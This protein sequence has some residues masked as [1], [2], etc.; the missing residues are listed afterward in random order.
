VSRGVFRARGG[1]VLAAGLLT[2]PADASPPFAR[3]LAEFAERPHAYASANCFFLVAQQEKRWD[4]AARLLDLLR[5]K[6]PD[7]DWLTL[8]RGN[9]EYSRDPDRALALY[10]QAADGFARTRLAEGEVTAR[11]N[12]RLILYRR[13]R[14]GEA[15][16]EVERAL[17][18]AQASGDPLTLARAWS[19]EA[20][21]LTDT[22]GDLS[23]ALA[24]LRRAE[25]AA[26]PAGSYTLRRG[27]V[28]ALGNACFQLGRFDEALSYYRRVIA[29][30]AETGD[31]LSRASAQYNVV[32][33]ML[34]QSEELPRPGA[35]TELVALAEDALRT[36]A[37]AD[38]REIQV[39][40]HRTLGELSGGR[41]GRSDASRAHYERCVALARR[42][43]Q[44]RELAHCLW[45]LARA[46]A[47]HGRGREARR[48]MD[49]ALALAG[50]TGHLW[51][52]A[53]ASRQRMRVAWATLPR[54]EAVAESLR[55]LSAIEAVRDVQPE[56]TGSAGVFSAWVSDYQ[57]LSGRLLATAPEGR[58][59]ALEQAFAVVER[60][61]ARVLL[62]ALRASRAEAPESQARAA[63]RKEVLARMLEA[64]RGLLDPGASPESRRAI[65]LR[66]EELEA[67][68]RALRPRAGRAV[69][70]P[71]FA[72]LEDVERALE[73]DEALLSY[74]V[75][76]DE[77]LLGEPAG[78][79]WVTV[80]T[81]AGTTAHRVAGRVRL[82]GS[83]PLFLGLFGARDGRE[84]RPAVALYRDVVERAVSGLPAGVGRL[85]VVPDDVLH[86]LPF[87]ALR[88]A[89]DA[90]PLGSRFAVTLAPSATLWLRW[91]R[92]PRPAALEPALVLADPALPGSA[93]R[94]TPEASE[95]GSL[96]D[97]RAGLGPLPHA[98]REGRRVARR[99]AGGRLLLGPAA[100]E[101]DLKR[102][103]L[104][105]YAVLHFATHAIVDD[106]HPDRSSLL[107]APGAA[108]EDGLLQS[109]EIA[110]LPL[111][112][113][114]VVLAACRSAG[115]S[116]VAGEGVMSL[117]RAFFQAGAQAVV[118]GLWPLRDDETEVVLD[119]FY[120]RLAGGE[121]L[122]Q[123]LHGAQRDAIA[124][125]LPGAAWA[126]LV[127]AGD[128]ALVPF[129]GG[130][131]SARSSPVPWL[132]AA[133]A[134]SIAALAL[135]ARRPG[136]GAPP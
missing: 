121:S 93:A 130:L 52:I 4:E 39:M 98:R 14:L 111:E 17:A 91:R 86:T 41:G 104:V 90:P 72:R 68:E 119:H 69:D 122:G 20:T 43:G 12:L 7:N 103:P 28:F 97:A 129:P 73:P 16:A 53:H 58:R 99:L 30:T 76:L 92:A 1:L 9:L 45:S 37:D 60:M 67:Q 102:S 55:S 56:E 50:R 94:A 2:A 10:R 101:A 15:G 31:L 66:L 57:W 108:G 8:A 118:G 32:N 70:P 63:A 33:T 105:D 82:R 23:T 120:R 123:A 42:I 136:T 126:G 83:V 131:R 74:H 100:A 47:E 116:L 117:A 107:L 113:R 64:H 84:T 25:R 89:E 26:F 40:L 106:A 48:R 71:A 6:R 19:L 18:A 78:G 13:G 88:G 35:R 95:R 134:L 36:A 34:R 133:A 3:C 51:S 81:R 96:D 24:S 46:L 115:G 77:D 80:S 11:H 114:V 85:V 29:M 21:H 44:P 62:D 59:D 110:D 112:G 38:N 22:G 124:A 128:A 127:V 132:V 49:E 109:R 5:A 61:R 27:I 54:H 65:A 79:G 135:R 125:R 87:A 75:G